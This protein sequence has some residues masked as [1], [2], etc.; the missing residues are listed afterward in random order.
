MV[1]GEGPDITAMIYEQIIAEEDPSAAFQ[2]FLEHADDIISA[3]TVSVSPRYTA[4]Q[5]HELKHWCEDYVKGILSSALKRGGSAK[6]FYMLLWDTI[7]ENSMLPGPDEIIFAI[8]MIWMNDCIPYFELE[9][10][11]R[12]TNEQFRDIAQK[13]RTQI[14]KVNYILAAPLKQ[15][16]ETCSL[17]L[18]VLSECETEAD[19]AVVMAQ[20]VGRTEQRIIR[21]LNEV[22][23]APEEV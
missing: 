23:S 12:M 13:N 11:L 3:K 5:I 18:R 19:R 16:T 7:N 20:V 2:Y 9:N 15:R 8:Y 4:S 14:K 21:M 6:E 17:L 22:Q 1:S 10:G